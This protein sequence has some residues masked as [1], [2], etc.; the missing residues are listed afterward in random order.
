MM[1][2]YNTRDLYAVPELTAD[3]IYI[4]ST[5]D[6]GGTKQS[7]Y[8]E[9]SHNGEVTKKEVKSPGFTVFRIKRD[10][11]KIFAEH[12]EENKDN[13]V[14]L[15]TALRITNAEEDEFV[16][17]VT[18]GSIRWHSALRDALKKYGYS[19]ND[20][21]EDAEETAAPF[22]FLGYKGLAPGY[23]IS[24]FGK[25][26]E[27]S[28]AEVSAYI[29]NRTFTSSKDG[30][31]GPQGESGETFY[32]WIKYADT[33]G[34]DGYPTDIY[35]K[36][37]GKTEYIGI[38]Y[39]C[40]VKE[41]SDDPKR[42][43]WTKTR[44]N[45]GVDGTSFRV[46]GECEE[47][48]SDHDAFTYDT[49][50]AQ[51]KIYLVDDYD[52]PT[53]DAK[54]LLWDGEAATDLNAQDGD[55]YIKVSN[56]VLFVKDGGSWLSL[57]TV[58]G[59]AGPQGPPGPPGGRGNP[60]PMGYP[61]GKWDKLKE[62]V[63]TDTL[64]PYV[65]HNGSYWILVADKDTGTEPK[66]ENDDV[67]GLMPYY[68]AFFVSLFF[69]NFAKLASGIISGDYHFS[70]YGLLNGVE[71]DKYEKFTGPD[72]EFMP[73][74]LIDYLNG[75]LWAQKCHIKGEVNATS[76]KFTN[77]QIDGSYGAPFSDMLS[78]ANWE[79]TLEEWR[80]ENYDRIK[81]HD[82]VILYDSTG[83]YVLSC[84][85]RDSGRSICVTSHLADVTI[86]GDGSKRFIEGGVLKTTIT[87]NNGEIVR[88]R[89]FGTDKEFKW[90][91]VES[92][93]IANTGMIRGSITGFNDK[94]V[95][96]GKV[97]ISGTTA[98]VVSMSPDSDVSVVRNSTGKYTIG[99][100]YGYF[101]GSTDKMYASV[102]ALGESATSA[103]VNSI[104]QLNMVVNTLR[105]NILCDSDFFFEIK[106]IG[107]NI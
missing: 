38:A 99:W 68:Q 94:V 12:F 36:P 65:E 37:T 3:Y 88:L 14:V 93:L 87:V 63:K 47:V 50:K 61:A 86:I 15:T 45:D 100:E 35:D 62:Y 72:G 48:Y 58:Q 105:Y 82:N 83:S 59:P 56:K 6:Y 54:A 19:G 89:G 102:T 5:N 71:S 75:E 57:G 11:L 74:L 55:A 24:Q 21:L 9:I 70:Q 33:V 96:R 91:I 106:V 13:L 98:T 92:R 97:K 4:K 42:Y 39:N 32:T 22:A 53:P 49:E 1:E 60:G 31:Q 8:I 23:G 44:G 34:S 67:W 17:V 104:S 25:A 28:V 90:Y 78:L 2:I 101:G 29:V 66:A 16:A 64:T 73:N 41:E 10:T 69:A 81:K 43:A 27:L 80:N 18:S 76:G 40:T 52:S 26:T 7:S 46:R 30:E 79:G 51:G 20:H 77:C 95:I 85:T 84:S 107:N 103:R